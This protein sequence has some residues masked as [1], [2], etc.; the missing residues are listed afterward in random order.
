MGGSRPPKNSRCTLSSAVLRLKDQA[1]RDLQK[2]LR[3]LEEENAIL[4][5]RCASSPTIGSEISVHAYP[6]LHLPD[7]E[8]VAGV[9]GLPERVLCMAGSSPESPDGAPGGTP[10]PDLRDFYAKSWGAT[11]GPKSPPPYAMR[12]NALPRKRWR[13]WPRFCHRFRFLLRFC[14]FN[15]TTH[16]FSICSIGLCP[17]YIPIYCTFRSFPRNKK[18]DFIF[19]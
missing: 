10:R 16:F 9:T 4:K 11:G 14:E 12:V 8:D 7:H 5:K 15:S 13:G 19:N 17:I 2:R 1:A 3:D 18:Q 6:P